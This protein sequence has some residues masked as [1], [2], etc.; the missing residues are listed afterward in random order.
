MQAALL[1]VFGEPL[2][3]RDVDRP[4]VDA[5]GVVVNVECCGVC[6]SDWHTWQGDWGWLD[7]RPTLPHVLGHEPC[8]TVV[9]TGIEITT[10][11]VGDAVVIP[12]TLACGECL[13]C[14]NGHENRCENRIDLGFSDAAPG[15][16]AEEVH[17]P[18]ADVNAVPLPDGIDATAAASMGCRFMTAYRAMAHRADVGRGEIVAVYGLG[19]VGLSTIQIAD[20][21]GCR[22][23]GVDL[24]D[25]KLDRAESLGAVATVDASVVDDPAAEVRAVSNG[26]TDIAVDALGNAETC[27][28]ALDSLA[29][30]GRHVQLG[31]T[32]G[33]EGGTVSLPIDEIVT[34]ELDL[35]GSHGLQPSRYGGLLDL[36]TA[37]KLDPGALVG[38]TVDIHDIP[39][40]LAAMT[41]YDT[42]G[43]PVCTD[44][45]G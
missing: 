37:G 34:R 40:T 22:V 29:D 13:R 2:A 19:G 25:E 36:V 31:L 8:G 7:A 27:R 5:D 18:R 32:S 21:L 45:S 41:D 28:N 39:D 4:T 3:V 24:V 14:R 33:K 9:E 11:A 20:A 16:F 43:I 23:I 26:G 15:A 12:F 42:V 38:E 17:V 44:F 6:R 10:V 35:C 30:G 1:E